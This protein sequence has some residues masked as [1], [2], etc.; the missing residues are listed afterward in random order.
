MEDKDIVNLYL[1][2]NKEKSND[3]TNYNGSIKY[4]NI[5]KN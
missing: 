1:Q 2:R 3:N 5:T 4:R